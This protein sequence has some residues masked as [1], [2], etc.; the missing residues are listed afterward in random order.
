MNKVQKPS[1]SEQLILLVYTVSGHVKT[2]CCENLDL[3]V[4]KQHKAGNTTKKRLSQYIVIVVVVATRVTSVT[5]RILEETRHEYIFIGHQKKCS[6][7]N[8]SCMRG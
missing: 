3:T 5:C 4:R 7:G 6:F 8:Q 2:K 1:N